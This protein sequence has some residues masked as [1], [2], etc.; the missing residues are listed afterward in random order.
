MTDNQKAIDGCIKSIMDFCEGNGRF[1]RYKDKVQSY[2][3]PK[4]GKSINELLQDLK[5]KNGVKLSVDGKTNYEKNVAL[6]KLISKECEQQGLDDTAI[7]EW[8]IKE[9][10]GI[11]RLSKNIE[12]YID[13]AKSKKYP[14]KLDGVASY[15][16]LFAMFHYKEFAIYDA[17]VAVS[18]NIV[19]LL[20]AEKNAIFFPFLP[21]RNKT[22]GHNS[23]DGRGFSR[24]KEFSREQI[25]N[26]SLQEWYTATPNNEVYG[27]YND[28]L[29]RV[30]KRIDW[31][32]HDIEMLLFSQAEDL[33]HQIRGQQKFNSVDWQSAGL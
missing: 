12:M 4:K 10:G 23:K 27:V 25:A 33:V 22:T 26:T 9:W 19:Q 29:K 1:G 14:V 7:S 16:K 6:K 11:S 15:S 24:L 28:I 21:G 8:I 17:R 5:P 2:E 20:A 18:L 31:P 30:S 32:L 13:C 3:W